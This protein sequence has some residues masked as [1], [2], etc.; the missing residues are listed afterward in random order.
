[1]EILPL[2]NS[3]IVLEK[4]QICLKPHIIRN[5]NLIYKILI[6]FEHWLLQNCKTDR[7]L[8]NIAKDKVKIL[9]AKE[10]KEHS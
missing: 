3:N 8:V 6:N 10:R 2:G 5:I 1:M 4:H 9:K 7:S